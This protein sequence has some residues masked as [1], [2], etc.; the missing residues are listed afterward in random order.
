MF[1]F[2]CSLAGRALQ[3]VMTAATLALAFAPAA[4]A[5]ETVSQAVPE[6]GTVSSGTVVSAGDPVQVILTASTAGTITIV[7]RTS[8]ARPAP[9]GGSEEDTSKPQYLGPRFEISGDATVGKVEVLVDGA[10]LPPSGYRNPE[11]GRFA[12]LLVNC[13]VP[14]RPQY[15]CGLGPFA[16]D[17]VSGGEQ[18]DGTLR[19][20]VQGVGGSDGLLLDFAKAGFQ[21]AVGGIDRDTL[22]GLL[23][24]GVFEGA[25]ACSLLCTVTPKV[26]VSRR[27]QRALGLK[28]RII[29]K[30]TL[31]G[32]TNGAAKGVNQP[33]TFKLSLEKGVAAVFRRK[34][35]A[36][37][38]FGTTIRYNGP[39]GETAFQDDG[40]GHKIHNDYYATSASK[41]DV[42][43]R[44]RGISSGE[45]TLTS[46]NGR[47]C[48][49]AGRDFE[50]PPEWE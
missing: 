23:R 18:P 19:G 30:E 22:G 11:G 13:N 2:R 44:V 31:T 7:K 29:A 17:Y 39:D 33:F 1:F 48:P 35:V 40:R 43:C 9:K 42:N 32:S 27:V 6:G 15:A 36:T 5:D 26:F 8:L 41:F 24:S 47:T 3:G 25:F 10:S 49:H 16:Q 28:S 21:A 45:L 38:S 37:I 4:S 20:E 14:N 46:R 50:G 34:H 12:A